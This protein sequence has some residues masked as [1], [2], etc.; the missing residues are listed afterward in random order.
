MR[1]REFIAVL[2]GSAAVW[3][4]AARAQQP[5]ALPV[6]GFLSSRSPDW[7]A[8][9]AFHQGLKETGHIDGQNVAV[10]YRWAEGHYD[11]L[12]EL[13]TEFVGR[14]VAVIAAVDGE[15]TPQAAEG[16]TR[17]IPIVFATASDPVGAGL[18]A[19]LNRP[20]G[21]ATGVTIF[22]STIIAKRLELLRE[23]VPT[24]NLIGILVNQS[25][26]NT[27]AETKDIETAAR[28]LGQRF[29][30]VR[31]STEHDL[32]AAFVTL[33]QQG[34]GA[35]LVGA[36]QFFTDRR[37]QIV[38]LAIHAR[39]PAIYHLR[40]FATAGGLISYG[41]S[42]ADLYRQVGNYVGRILKGERPADLPVVQP[43]NF[44]LVINLKAAKALGLTVPLTL[45][46]AADEVIE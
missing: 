8:V 19:S 2:G 25:N 15:P 32:D 13:A 26:P 43:T 33:V 16:A 21:N 30:V 28:E 36:D 24:A 46:V 45:Q 22:G 41:N 38:A 40:D 29:Y 31:A 12:P 35:L 34:A 23:L 1:R 6:V 5:S 27:E 10:E 18:V 9:T 14:S 37:D 42:L 44:E 4:L 17:T 3:P 7:N 11:R 20:G 39:I